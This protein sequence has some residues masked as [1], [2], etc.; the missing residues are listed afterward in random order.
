MQLVNS[1]L[2][3]SC[4]AQSPSRPSQEKEIHN[5]GNVGRRLFLIVLVLLVNAAHLQAQSYAIADLGALPG[6]NT[7]KAYG[8]NNLGQAVGI[9]D[10]GAA[11]AT[12]FRN[13]TATN[14]NT[15]NADVSVATCISGSTQAAGYNIFYSNPNLIFRAFLYGNGGMTD[16]QSDSLFPF[17][18]QAYGIN[19]SGMVVGQ[20]WVTNESFHVFLYSGGRMVDLG[21]GFQASASAINDAGQIVGNGTAKGAFLYS[22]GKMVSLGVPSGANSSWANAINSTGNMVAGYLFFS[23]HP[24]HASLHSNGGWTDLGAFPGAA[25]TQ[26]TG[27]DSS[28][29]VVGTA[30]FPVQSY[31][32]FRPGKH[33]GF[34]H[35]NDALVD[36]N[37]LIPSN[38]GFTVTD[39]I[40][41]NDSG[42]ILCDATNSSNV[43]RAVLLSSK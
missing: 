40:G 3:V 42:Q 24:S 41:I 43:T 12:L 15:L 4:A 36:L 31:H 26:A 25:G 11:T 39:A 8:L 6:N 13:G 7:S 14:M 29:Q 22:N 37:T 21:G 18:T 20:G 23:G 30:V 19:S 10:S 27:V 5:H 16:I 17:G 9:S 28:G 38:S 2:F 33:V 35:R 1:P 32:P 34:I